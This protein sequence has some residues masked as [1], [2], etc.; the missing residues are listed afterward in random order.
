MMW[1]PLRAFTFSELL[2]SSIPCN[3]GEHGWCACWG[4]QDES[5]RLF[6]RQL[7]TQVGEIKWKDDQPG[8]AKL[9]DQ[10][11]M[12]TSSASMHVQAL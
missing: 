9:P 7:A 12:L 3:V 2:A 11:K 6:L 8:V 5:T 10:F 1:E 4:L